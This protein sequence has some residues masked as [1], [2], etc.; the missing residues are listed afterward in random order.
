MKHTRELTGYMQD[1][2]VVPSHSGCT[3]VE[4]PKNYY[5]NRFLYLAGKHQHPIIRP[6]ETSFFKFIETQLE[7]AVNEHF[8]WSNSD[9]RNLLDD[10]E[11]LN[12]FIDTLVIDGV[13][14]QEYG[15][16][17]L[18][19]ALKELNNHIRDSIRMTFIKCSPYEVWFKA[20]GYSSANVVFE[21][22]NDYRVMEWSE[23]R[24]KPIVD[25]K[26]ENSL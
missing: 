9:Y 23:G 5:L 2:H 8:I 25:K 4:L 18:I 11:L 6:I 16:P 17:L 20:S 21:Y 13:L 12:S 24:G 1:D 19:D 10:V 3:L 14:I 22:G 15:R 7:L 26:N